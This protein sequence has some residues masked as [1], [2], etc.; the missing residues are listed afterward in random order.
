[1]FK[2][3]HCTISQSSRKQCSV[4]KSTTEAEYVALSQATQEAMWMRQLISDIGCKPQEPTNMYE[5]NQGA[6]EISRNPKFHLRTKHITIILSEKELSK[7]K[8]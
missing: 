6:I 7:R 8:L 3:A 5:D 1:M 4:A 2:V